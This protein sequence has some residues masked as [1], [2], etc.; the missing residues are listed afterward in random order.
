LSTAAFIPF[1]AAQ[2]RN[3]SVVYHLTREQQLFMGPALDQ[4]AIGHAASVWG[5]VGA[6]VLHG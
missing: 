6:A 2:R 4:V 5:L 1:F 3:Q